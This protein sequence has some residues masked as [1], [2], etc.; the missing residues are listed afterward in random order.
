[1]TDVADELMELAEPWERGDRVKAA[2]ERAAR[3][4]GL[5]YWR[6]FDIW[7]GKARRIEPEERAAISDALEKKRNEATRNELHDLR[8]RLARLEARLVQSDPDFSR[9]GTPA[10]GAGLCAAGAGRR[11]RR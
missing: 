3:R 1:M 2:I 6:A 9:S 10:A 8:L 11:G 7:Y 5:S 4:C